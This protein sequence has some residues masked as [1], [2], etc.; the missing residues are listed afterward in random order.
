MMDPEDSIERQPETSDSKPAG[1]PR[2]LILI[3]VASLIGVLLLIWWVIPA[4]KPGLTRG[5]KV[6][7]TVVHLPS[8]SFKALELV[9]PCE[10]T[11]AL[12]IGVKTKGKDAIGVFMVGPD[13]LP[14]M[15]AKQTFAH[16][17]GFDTSRTTRYLRSAR[18]APGRYGLVI[19]SQSSA[20]VLDVQV[21]ARL[22]GLK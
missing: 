6:L 19:M 1:I 20:P 16:L 18:L 12:D 5:L 9:L 21:S 10:G 15:K 3:I 11:L 22:I 14:K 17:K 7:D 2:R 8:T 4:A 13:Q